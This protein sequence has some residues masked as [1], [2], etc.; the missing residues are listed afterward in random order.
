MNKC[1]LCFSQF[2][3]SCLRLCFRFFTLVFFVGD[4]SAA[5]KLRRRRLWHHC[6]AFFDLRHLAVHP[7]SHV[8]RQRLGCCRQLGCYW[9]LQQRK[10]GGGSM[11]E[12]RSNRECSLQSWDRSKMKERNHRP[13]F[14]LGRQAKHIGWR[15]RDK[16]EQDR[17]N[18]T[19][20]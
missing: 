5:T 9:Q 3:Q 4:L 6:V 11:H 7:S 10:L 2:V 15:D 16:K 20:I 1:A 18:S 13:V 12:D 8:N 14:L 17:S 19:S